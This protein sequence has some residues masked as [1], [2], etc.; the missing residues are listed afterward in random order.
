MIGRTFSHY[1][2]EE[3]IG[4]GGMGEVYRAI[5]TRLGRKVAIKALSLPKIPSA[6]KRDPR[7]VGGGAVVQPDRPEAVSRRL[8]A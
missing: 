5:D 6:S 3:K 8:S 4:G 1:R 7:E 2:I